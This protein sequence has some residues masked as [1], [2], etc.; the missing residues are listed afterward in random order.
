MKFSHFDPRPKMFTHPWFKASVL[1]IMGTRYLSYFEVKLDLDWNR[2]CIYGFE[3]GGGYKVLV[4]S[5][6][7][8]T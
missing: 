4:T 7:I 8:S 3:G 5:R 2:W 1:R 6:I